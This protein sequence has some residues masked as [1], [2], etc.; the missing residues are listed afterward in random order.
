LCQMAVLEETER[1][2]TAEAH[3]RRMLSDPALDRGLLASLIQQVRI[4][5]DK[6]VELVFRFSKPR[7]AHC[8]E[9][10]AG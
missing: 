8:A 4:H 10:Q 6:T 1:E 2:E 7:D 3:I 5:Q 9:H